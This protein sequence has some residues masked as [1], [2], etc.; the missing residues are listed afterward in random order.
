[1][2]SNPAYNLKHIDKESIKP[3]KLLGLLMEHEAFGGFI[4][5]VLLNVPLAS[6]TFT[7]QHSILGKQRV[8]IKLEILAEL[9]KAG[10]R[11]YDPACGMDLSSR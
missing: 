3:H 7:M 2:N 11:V 5:N 9:S 8:F 6:W 10:L 4:E 1:M